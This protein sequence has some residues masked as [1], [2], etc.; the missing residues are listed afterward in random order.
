MG[1]ED[2]LKQVKSNYPH[3]DL[4]KVSMDEPLPTTPAGDAIP[5]GADGTI[6]SE[7]DTQ[8]DGVILAKFAVNPLISPLTPSANPPVADDPSSQDA[9]DQTKGNETPQDLPAS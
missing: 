1:F 2:C 6:E 7:Q 8:D 3:L 4:A 5:E 9:P